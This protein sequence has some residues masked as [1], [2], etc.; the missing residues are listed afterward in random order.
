MECDGVLSWPS[1]EI[2]SGGKSEAEYDLEWGTFVSKRID[3]C[4]PTDMVP[5]FDQI[6]RCAVLL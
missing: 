4:Y 5:D 1:N 3:H 6:Q 2:M